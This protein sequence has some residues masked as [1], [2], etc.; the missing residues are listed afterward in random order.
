VSD[1][2]QLE[3]TSI[4]SIHMLHMDVHRDTEQT[5]KALLLPFPSCQKVDFHIQSS[6]EEQGLQL[7]LHV[8]LS[9]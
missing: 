3:N 2:Y 8:Y 7:S 5:E 1:I 4:T 9:E 6:L